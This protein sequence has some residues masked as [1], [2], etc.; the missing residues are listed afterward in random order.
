MVGERGC[1]LCESRFDLF[2]DWS[3]IDAV[4]AEIEGQC[5]K[6]AGFQFALM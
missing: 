2:E 3:G 6:L 5:L 4:R 1:F